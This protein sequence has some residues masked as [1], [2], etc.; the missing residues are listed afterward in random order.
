[1]YF[2]N[3]MAALELISPMT[4][5]KFAENPIDPLESNKNPL[6]EYLT[7]ILPLLIADQVAP[8]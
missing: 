7:E 5:C 4:E 2:K 3:T 8:C 1:M 6:G